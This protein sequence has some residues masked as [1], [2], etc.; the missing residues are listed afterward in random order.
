MFVFFITIIH[1]MHNSVN[2][3]IAVCE[4]NIAP[5]CS[6][7]HTGAFI[8]YSWG[9]EKLRERMHWGHRG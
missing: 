1:H 7:E 5:E 3:I 6:S 2:T 9:P 4:N 8:S